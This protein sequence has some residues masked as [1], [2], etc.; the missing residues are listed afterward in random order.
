MNKEIVDKKVKTLDLCVHCEGELKL[1]SGGDPFGSLFGGS[2]S[3][4]CFYCNNSE[5]Q[6][7]GVL[8]L[9]RKQKVEEVEEKVA[10]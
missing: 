5:C 1:T 8:T 4:G 3:K 7:Y 10:G 9:A 6:F 2:T